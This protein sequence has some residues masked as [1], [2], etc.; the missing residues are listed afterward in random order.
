M[1][2]KLAHILCFV[3]IC[4]QFVIAENMKR[5]ELKTNIDMQSILEEIQAMKDKI[6]N[7][8]SVIKNE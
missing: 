3:V 1:D 2:L 7:H 4:I 6:A 5:S 8:E